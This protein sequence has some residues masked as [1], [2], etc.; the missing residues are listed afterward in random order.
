MHYRIPIIYAITDYMLKLLHNK[1]CTWGKK[2]WLNENELKLVNP[3]DKGLLWLLFF[4][5]ENYKLNF[6][7]VFQLFSITSFLCVCFCSSKGLN[8]FNN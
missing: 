6:I 7:H 3:L 8:W 5:K 1:I 4:Y 2:E